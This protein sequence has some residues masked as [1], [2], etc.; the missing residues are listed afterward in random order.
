MVISIDVCVESCHEGSWDGQRGVA[1]KC[2]KIFLL[3][4]AAAAGKHPIVSH[5]WDCTQAMKKKILY[6]SVIAAVLG[7][8]R[9]SYI[10]LAFL[11]MRLEWN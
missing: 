4:W 2:C 11:N 7:A 3:E 10:T 9:E 1:K 8:C 5:M 6:F